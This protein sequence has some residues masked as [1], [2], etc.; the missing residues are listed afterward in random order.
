MMITMNQMAVNVQSM[1]NGMGQGNSPRISVGLER[2][3]GQFE[4]GG[5]P[6]RSLRSRDESKDDET[7]A[8][9]PRRDGYVLI[10]WGPE[11]V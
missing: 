8:W 4:G 2:Q 1:N 5:R 10:T 7:S 9:S 3:L 6:V 11:I